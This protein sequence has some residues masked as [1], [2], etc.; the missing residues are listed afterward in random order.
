MKGPW[1]IVCSQT[2]TDP[3]RWTASVMV[4]GN[5]AVPREARHSDEAVEAAKDAWRGEMGEHFADQD[6]VVNVDSPT[7]VEEDHSQPVAGEPVDAAPGVVAKD[8]S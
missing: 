4:D 6:F 5:P 2:S 1:H 8:N 7:V 3:E